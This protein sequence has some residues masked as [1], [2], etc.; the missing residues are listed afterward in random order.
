M[1]FVTKLSF[2]SGD[3]EVLDRVVN[4]IKERAAR[5]GVQLKGPHPHPATEV[6]APQYKR[7]QPGESFE[8]WSF[9]VYTRDIEIHDH[10]QFARE[11]AGDDYPESIH[12][13]ADVEQ[14]TG[15]GA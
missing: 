11:V 4:D 7:L 6:S 2:E 5:K 15:V 14:R 13:E 9:S 1:P 10:D 3:R 8:A 12:I